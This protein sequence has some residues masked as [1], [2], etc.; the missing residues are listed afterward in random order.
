MAPVWLRELAIMR[1]VVTGASG[2]IGAYLLEPLA[3]TG[4]D[5]VPWS[6]GS[7]GDW[8]STR[9]VPVAL[10]D[11]AAVDRAL[12]QADPAV[13]LHAG[14]ISAADQVFKDPERG[15]VVN[16]NATRHLAEW[17]RDR[18]RRIVFTS[19][20][21]VFDGARSWYVEDDEP[22]PI[23]AYGR[24]KR[25]AEVEV[26]QTPGGVVARLALLYGLTRC[27]RDGFFDRAVAA[28]RAGRPQT[29]FHDEYRTPLDYR[30]S[31]QTL[32]ELVRSDFEG[33]VHVGGRERLSRLEF[34]T[35]A[36]RAF[37]LDES[38]VSGNSRT[39]V[40]FAE[41]RPADVSLNTARLADV[42]P[43]LDRPLIEE[44]VRRM[45]SEG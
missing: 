37:G 11:L 30:T 12:A 10:T 19:T 4:W 25:D 28:L 16:V 41:P 14:A 18:G 24:T 1:I 33:I 35:R 21:M 34:M 31:A 9:F 40:V 45:L 20:D 32:V 42:L 8:G 6:G 36:A 2:Q 23:S 7:Q 13:V 43:D 44:A 29:F 38:L 27:G 17:C 39:E 26:L 15:R 22:R 3:R 5:V